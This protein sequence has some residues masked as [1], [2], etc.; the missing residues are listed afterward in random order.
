M[1]RFL[2]LALVLSACGDNG[3]DQPGPGAP[4]S[5]V[6]TTQPGGAG[7]P[8]PMY[9]PQVCGDLRWTTTDGSAGVDVS[10]VPRPSGAQVLAVPLS[11]GA[12]SGYVLDKQMDMQTVNASLSIDDVFT[13]VSA[14]EVRGQLVSTA[15]DESS[16][17]VH[18]IADDMS[19]A[20]NI[21]K[22]PPGF[23]AK[24]AFQRSDFVDFIPVADAQGLRLERFN[25][26]WENSTVRAATTDFATGLTA[27][28]MGHSTVAAW[29]T[30]GE[31][32]MMTLF[33]P[34]PGPID[35][36]PEACTSPHLAIDSGTQRGQLVYEG[37]DGIRT[38]ST[39]H[40]RFD[41]PS[42]LLR[43]EGTSPRV[44]WDGAR[45]WISYID[46]R[47]D[48]VIGYLDGGDSGHYNSTAI[49]GPRPGSHAYELTL[50]G[51]HVWVVSFDDAGY[52]ATRLCIGPVY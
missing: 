40:V 52:T 39:S 49:V 37:P 33:T 13:S 8:M 19:K 29:A 48:I 34:Q 18:L 7:V 26:N 32:Y 11:G 30:K 44:L 6:D 4:V 42:Q 38:I 22:L 20:V 45:F 15:R 3:I 9:V 31:C 36:L 47:G 43:K 24:P 28:P 51:G 27:A 41:G 17:Q 1:G 50:I 14:S 21:A 2:A 35:S 16:L 12:M 23:I 5:G 46:R 25:S 10:I